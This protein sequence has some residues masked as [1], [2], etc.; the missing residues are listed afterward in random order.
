MTKEMWLN[1]PVK[2]LDKTKEFFSRIGFSLDEQHTNG[3][4]VCFNVGEKQMN[5]LFFAEETFRGFTKSDVSDASKSAEVL[6]SFDADSRE[7][8]DETARKVF[9]AGGTIFSAPA[10]IQGWM[11]GC[12]FADLDGHRWNVLYMDLSR[13]PKA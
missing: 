7:E 10:E 12:G 9:E 3:E 11:Y 8:V 5:V 1:F 6:I 13:M 2:D 4:M